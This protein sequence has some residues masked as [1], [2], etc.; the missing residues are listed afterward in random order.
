MQEASR[1]EATGTNSFKNNSSCVGG[2]GEGRQPAET[3]MEE[4]EGETFSQSLE[5]REDLNH[6]LM[7]GEIR[8]SLGEGLE[9]KSNEDVACK[10]VVRQPIDYVIS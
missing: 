7:V 5:G 1:E 8:V 6:V 10:E 3:V 2:A 4:E 9:K